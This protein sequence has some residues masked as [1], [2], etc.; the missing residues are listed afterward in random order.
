MVGD[1]VT[2][3]IV[4]VVAELSYM[5]VFESMIEGRMTPDN[6]PDYSVKDAVNLNFFVYPA[7]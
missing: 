1:F 4:N 7:V 3:Y 2:T 5:Q 6:L